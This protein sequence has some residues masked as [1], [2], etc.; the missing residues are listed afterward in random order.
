MV[1]VHLEL[2]GRD[3]SRAAKRGDVTVIVDALRSSSTII[4]ALSNGARGI[5]PARTL[6]EAIQL[7][8]RHPEALLAGERNM[9]KP[10]TFHMGNSPLEYARNVVLGRTIILTTTDGTKAIKLASKGARAV[11]IGAF[12]NASSVARAS[13]DLALKMKADI[14]LIAV[15][16]KGNFAL[17]DFLG[18]GFIIRR[19]PNVQKLIDSALMDDSA[20][21]AYYSAEIA[22]KNLKEV[23]YQGE[24]AKKLRAFGLYKDVEFCSRVDIFNSVPILEKSILVEY[25]IP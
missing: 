15:G 9:V 8:E 19:L 17:E 2:I 16:K 4:T 7:S 12:L 18:A 5:I 22:E 24:H 14:S 11:L 25:R 23:I 6:K 1:R 13:Y 3:A 21:W 10:P 20:L